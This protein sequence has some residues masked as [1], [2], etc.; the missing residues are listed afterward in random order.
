MEAV[1]QQAGID[2]SG[3]ERLE[4]GSGLPAHFKR[5]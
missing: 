2:C 4:P 3:F 1:L 5:V